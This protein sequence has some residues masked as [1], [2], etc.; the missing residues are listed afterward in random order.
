MKTIPSTVSGLPIDRQA[1][2]ITILNLRQ[3]IVTRMKGDGRRH[4]FTYSLTDAS[5]LRLNQAVGLRLRVIPW[6]DNPTHIAEL[7]YTEE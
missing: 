6:Y 3:V 2:F 4:S 5:L 1:Q 7:V